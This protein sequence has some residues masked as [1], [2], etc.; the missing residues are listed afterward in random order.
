MIQHRKQR[1]LVVDNSVDIGKNSNQLL[2]ASSSLLQPFSLLVNCARTAIILPPYAQI[3]RLMKPSHCGSYA[4]LLWIKI[5]G[6]GGGGGAGRSKPSSHFLIK[7]KVNKIGAFL[8][9]FLLHAICVFFCLI[10]TRNALRLVIQ[11][12]ACRDRWFLL[13]CMFNLFIHRSGP[14]WD[15]CLSRQSSV[16]EVRREKFVKPM[17]KKTK[18][19]PARHTGLSAWPLRWVKLI[20]RI[21]MLSKRTDVSNCTVGWDHNTLTHPNVRTIFIC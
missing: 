14:V 5:R 19:Q 16:E 1:S 12:L 7:L 3:W 4:Y 11:L 6:G 13:S 8:F 9:R 2:A 21:G 18:N 20:W 10:L 17:Q 15:H